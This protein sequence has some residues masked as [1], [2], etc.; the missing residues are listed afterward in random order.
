MGSYTQ[1]IIFMK[2]I[3]EILGLTNKIYKWNDLN[4]NIQKKIIL[5]YLLSIPFLL[6]TIFV[7]FMTS[8]FK[9]AAVFFVLFSFYLLF[10][11]Y[12]H[13]CFLHDAIIY[14]TGLI[15]KTSGSADFSIKKS[16]YG[17]H[18]IVVSYNEKYYRILVPWSDLYKEGVLVTVCS[19]INNIVQVDETMFDIY[20]PIIVYV[21]NQ[22]AFFTNNT[23]P[24][25]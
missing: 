6:L 1:K 23:I 4:I 16:K 18:E 11:I 8:N 14:T 2:M 12:Q 3:K 17:K 15:V 24:H 20:S 21:N 7:G 25:E 10:V 13:L 5:S 9:N 19:K 22:D